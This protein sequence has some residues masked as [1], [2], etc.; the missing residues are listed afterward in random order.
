MFRLVRF[1]SRRWINEALLG[2]AAGPAITTNNIQHIQVVEAVA[3][4]IDAGTEAHVNE[5]ATQLALD[6]SGASRMIRDAVAAGYLTRGDSDHDRRR[7]VI[8]LTAQGSQLLSQARQWQQQCFDNLTS[9]WSDHD[10]RLFSSYL[11]RLADEIT[12]PAP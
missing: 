9:T 2:V 10:R 11:K 4:V 3:T 12:T 1:W 7:V 6:Q 5:V 8:E